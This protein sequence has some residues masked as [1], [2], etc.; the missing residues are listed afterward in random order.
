MGALEPRLSEIHGSKLA[1][2]WDLVELFRQALLL[3]QGP[4]WPFLGEEKV[5][6]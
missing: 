5:P 1:G 2:H 4:S 6:G 3:F